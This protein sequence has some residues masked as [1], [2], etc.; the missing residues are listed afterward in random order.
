M[1]NETGTLHWLSGEPT[2][3]EACHQQ[4]LELARRIGS[5]QDEA[6]GLVGLGRCAAAVGHAKR[7]KTLLQQAQVIFQRIGTTDAAALLAELD[8]LTSPRPSE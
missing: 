7:A 5:T 4:A 8:T 2:Q 1:L 6:R 3:A